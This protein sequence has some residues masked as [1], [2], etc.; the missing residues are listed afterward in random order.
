[1]CAFVVAQ[2]NVGSTV[3]FWCSDRTLEWFLAELTDFAAAFIFFCERGSECSLQT[4]NGLL[5]VFCCLLC[6]KLD[7]SLAHLH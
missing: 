5:L 7:M 6:L 2:H 4:D 3:G 1:M